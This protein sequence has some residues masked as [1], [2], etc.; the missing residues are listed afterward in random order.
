MFLDDDIELVAIVG[1]IISYLS[2]LMCFPEFI[3]V[4][5]S[6]RWATKSEYL[7]LF[8]SFLDK[9]MHPSVVPT[10]EITT[11]FFLVSVFEEVSILRMEDRESVSRV[12]FHVVCLASVLVSDEHLTDD[13]SYSLL[14][15]YQYSSVPVPT[16]K[17]DT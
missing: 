12:F 1:I 17:F 10:R 16:H 11:G 8:S 5:L 14:P 7:E 2:Y 4:F 6:L 13:K 9:K 3:N 15:Q